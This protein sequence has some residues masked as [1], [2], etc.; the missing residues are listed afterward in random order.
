MSLTVNTDYDQKEQMFRNF[1][2]GVGPLSSPVLAYEFDSGVA[3]PQNLTVLWID[4]LDK[5]ADVNYLQI[6]ESALVGFDQ[7]K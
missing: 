7:I 5:L 1:L 4:P 2:G 3:V 6:E